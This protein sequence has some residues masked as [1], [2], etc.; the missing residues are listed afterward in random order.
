M[1]LEQYTY[2]RIMDRILEREGGYV[3]HK[4]D[5]G[6]E[7]NFGITKAVAIENK[8]LW[9]KYG[10]DGNMKSMPKAF[11]K[12]VYRLRYWNKVNGDALH[13][14]HPLLADHLFDFGINAGTGTAVKHL[15]RALNA[16][17]RK[18]VDYADVGVDGALG[19]GTLRSLEAYV[20]KRGKMGLENLIVALVMMQWNHYLII[21]ENREANESFTNGWLERAANKMITYAK[22]M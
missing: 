7:T 17:N 11:A 8:G 20:R 12:E 9:S 22:E 14:I 13:R 4:D 16:L 3:N 10:W 18:Q 19:Q 21:T 2:D 1:S 5:T 15:Q 6:G